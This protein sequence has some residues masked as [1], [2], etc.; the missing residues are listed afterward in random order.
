MKQKNMIQV[1]RCFMGKSNYIFS[2][3]AEN[4]PDLKEYLENSKNFK[5]FTL[6]DGYPSPIW[7][8]EF[9]RKAPDEA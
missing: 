1:W 7:H 6:T 4:D 3:L 9:I 8:Y 5:K 2:W